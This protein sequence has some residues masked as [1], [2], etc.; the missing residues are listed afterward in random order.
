MV[1]RDGLDSAFVAHA[2]HLLHHG[3]QLVLR[4]LHDLG[5]ATQ[6]RIIGIIVPLHA[7]FGHLGRFVCSD[8]REKKKELSY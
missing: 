2:M 4:W 8:R 1:I 6:E 5:E 3:A 7:S